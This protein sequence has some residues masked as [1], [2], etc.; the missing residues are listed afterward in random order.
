MQ[1][2]D[3]ILLAIVEGVTEFLPISSTAHL[4]LVSNALNIKQTEFVKTFEIVIQLGAMAPVIIFYGKKFLIDRMAMRNIII[5]FMPAA[6]IG[7]LL[8]SFI[9]EVLIGNTYVSLAALLFGGLFLIVFEKFYRSPL[10]VVVTRIESLS[11]RQALAIGLFQSAA[12]IPGVSRAGASIIGGMLGGL[13]RKTAVEF[14]FLLAVPTMAAASGLD[15][16]ATRGVFT[17][18]EY[19]MLALGFILS[20]IVAY[21]A[22]R[23]LLRFVSH[24]DLTVFGIYRIIFSVGY[25]LFMN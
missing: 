17:I 16:F 10:R 20:A 3:I 13:S 22:V 21:G 15:L 5:A 12:I 6:I 7:G 18:E 24:H 9:K 14:S 11:V 1:L 4:V 25:L 19:G 23:W 2:I 8:Y